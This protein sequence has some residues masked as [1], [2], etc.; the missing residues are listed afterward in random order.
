MTFQRKSSI[1]ITD[2]SAFC[3]TC[4]GCGASLSIPATGTLKK[5]KLERCPTCDDQWSNGSS[6]NVKT[7]NE[8]HDALAILRFAVADKERSGFRFTLELASDPASTAK[9]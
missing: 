6:G 2:I 1:D 8:F 3:F 4:H 9:D 5:G 7:V